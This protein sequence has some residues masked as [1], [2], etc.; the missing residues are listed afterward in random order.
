MKMPKLTFQD[1]YD[2]MLQGTLAFAQIEQN[3]M[4]LDVGYLDRMIEE[5]GTEI[6]QKEEALKE[7]PIWKTWTKIYG[8]D[9]NLGS[10]EQLGRVIFDEMKIE[11]KRRT[12]T[13]K[14]ATDEDSLESV[15]FPFVK[16]WVEVGKLKRTRT[17]NLVGLRNEQVDGFLHPHFNLNTANSYRSSAS[18]PNSQNFPVRNPVL[19]KLV[20]TA[21]IPH[22]EGDVFLEID[23]SGAEVRV[24]ACYHKDPTMIDYILDKSKDMH[25]D[26]AMQCF[27]LEKDQMVKNI[28]N[29]AKGGFVFAEFYGDWY[30]QVCQ[31]LWNSIE[32]EKLKTAQGVGLKDHLAS[33]GIKSLG[34]LNPKVDSPGSF[35]EH[36][37][38]VEHDFW[39]NRFPVYTEWKNQLWAE[40]LKNGFYQ[41]LTGF[42]V[43]AVLSRNQA[44]N[45]GIQGASFHCLLWALI[46]IQ[47]WLG[48]RKLKSKIIGQIHDSILLNVKR[49]EFDEVLYTCNRIMTKDI[50]ETWDWLIV[51]MEVEAEAS[52]RNWFEKKSVE[53]PEFSVQ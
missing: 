42:I 25:R 31:N 9:S 6:K 47:K 15:D 12:A 41:M 45:Y 4:R 11:C 49:N 40:Y 8:S 1:S 48:R 7:D 33:K 51:P 23:F 14:P 27:M 13:G 2:L 34:N 19:A 32:T 43:R 24:A 35:E 46:Q 39:Y 37:K 22:E 17:T 38:E 53:I 52:D 18:D 26:M 36:I 21:F 28:R 29:T 30:I 10:G 44:I 5:V 50:R 16:K 3:G 20:R